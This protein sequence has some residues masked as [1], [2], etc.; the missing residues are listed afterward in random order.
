VTPVTPRPRRARTIW[1]QRRSSVPLPWPRLG[2]W[3]RL[4][5]LRLRLRP[6][7]GPL[8]L[9]PAPVATATRLGFEGRIAGDA[10]RVVARAEVWFA[11]EAP[12]API[13]W[14]STTTGFTLELDD[15]KHVDVP[16]GP[17]G[18][19]VTG[20]HPRL[21]SVRPLHPA[22]DEPFVLV[23]IELRGGQRIRLHGDVDMASPIGY[24][25]EGQGWTV[26]SMALVRPLPQTPALALPRAPARKALRKAA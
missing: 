9:P 7:S 2:W 15:G 22:G 4:R 10:D 17:L 16:F 23:T 1:I 19:D 3:K 8:R 14:Q 13:A 5:L 11:P 26:R 21:A 6:P 20:D 24:R 12:L 25:G 18:L